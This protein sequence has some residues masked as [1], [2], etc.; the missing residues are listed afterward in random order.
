MTNFPI[1]MRML[2]FVAGVCLIA[3]LGL[4]SAL[5]HWIDARTQGGVR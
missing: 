2:G 5:D 3:F 1:W 4:L